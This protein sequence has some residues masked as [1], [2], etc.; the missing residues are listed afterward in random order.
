MVHK[1]LKM[2]KSKIQNC[3]LFRA[4]EYKFDL[5]LDVNFKKKL[6]NLKLDKISVL[7][8]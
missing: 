3:L 7:D 4:L 1:D 5:N 8:L 6:W 2:S